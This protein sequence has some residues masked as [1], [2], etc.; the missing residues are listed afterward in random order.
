M[1]RLSSTRQKFLFA[2]LY[3]CE[4][5]PI[6]FIWWAL[7]TEMRSAGVP[8]DRITLITGTL[9]LPWAFKFLWAPL[10][11]SFQSERWN[12]KTWIISS[13]IVMSLSLFPLL[14]IDESIPFIIIYISLL[15]HTIAAATQ[16]VSIDALCIASVPPERHGMMNGWMQVGML[17][18]RSLFGGVALI[19]A[20]SIG[21]EGV[22]VAMI[23][24]LASV[25][26]ML[27]FIAL[28]G[29]HRESTFAATRKTIAQIVR[30]RSTW[31]GLGFAVVGGAAFE[32]VGSVAGPFM[33]DRGLSRETIGFFFSILSVSAMMAGAL[34]G[35]AV[36]DRIGKHV[37]ARS[38][39]TVVAVIV[40]IIAAADHFSDTIHPN[41][42]LSLLMLLYCG[43]GIFT[44]ASYA[45]FMSATDPRLGATQ[46]ST[47]MGG[48]NLSESL[49]TLS[50]GMLIGAA[51]Y[52]AAFSVL[53][54]ISLL[55][56][57]FIR[58]IEPYHHANN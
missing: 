30:R 12:L 47:F 55:S 58:N 40:L 35:G 5:A 50:A 27:L 31:Y 33:I 28:P 8:V 38:A 11:D 9:V 10:V 14:L 42:I 44:A 16:D 37:A 20:T 39:T 56:L 46:F 4:G 36:S 26:V 17:A 54:F 15:I 7:P 29:S 57:P 19:V 23:A 2:L 25:S 13:Q 18:G 52:P 34:L 43:I 51:G 24:L 22:I 48:T 6:G 45:L 3:F 1:D 41:M 32:G 53:A 21:M 49:S